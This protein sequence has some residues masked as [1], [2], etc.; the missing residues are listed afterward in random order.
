MELCRY[1]AAAAER[2]SLRKKGILQQRYSSLYVCIFYTKIANLVRLAAAAQGVVDCARGDPQCR[3]YCY[4]DC[5]LP[6]TFHQLLTAF[7]LCRCSSRRRA[8]A[9]TLHTLAAAAGGGVHRL[10]WQHQA[11]VACSCFRGCAI[12]LQRSWTTV[13][14]FWCI[15]IIIIVKKVQLVLPKLQVW[16]QSKI[17]NGKL[18]MYFC[19]AA[20]VHKCR[21]SSPQ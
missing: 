13:N 11:A 19:N 15:I 18:Q 3:T 17:F 1:K 2:H 5:E 14:N 20:A 4:F 9:R 10:Q 12:S 21:S 16:D 8:A 6:C 7:T